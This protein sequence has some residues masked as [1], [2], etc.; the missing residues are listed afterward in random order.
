MISNDHEKAINQQIVIIS[1]ILEAKKEAS[2]KNHGAETFR[3][4]QFDHCSILLLG[5]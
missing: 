3:V 2:A 1:A 4:G 5:W